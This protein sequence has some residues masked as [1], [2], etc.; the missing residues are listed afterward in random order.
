MASLRNPRP[1][2][3]PLRLTLTI[4]LLALASSGF[5]VFVD[6]D[7][8]PSPHEPASA[9]AAQQLPLRPAN[10]EPCR[11]VSFATPSP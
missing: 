2:L 7:D 3:T 5:V 10:P 4:A 11:P 1:C 6:Q 9:R 8:L